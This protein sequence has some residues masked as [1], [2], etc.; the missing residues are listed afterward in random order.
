MFKLA[1]LPAENGDCLWIEYGEPDDPHRILIDTGTKEA[2]GPLRKKILS[3]DTEHR[4]F[5]LMIMSHYDNDHILGA[6]D[7]FQDDELGV[8]FGDI[9][10]NGWAHISTRPKDELGPEE[11]EIFSHFIMKKRLPW[12][13]S[14]SSKA[15]VLKGESPISKTLP[16]GMQITLLSPRSDDLKK[17][18]EDWESRLSDHDL[19]PGFGMEDELPADVLGGDIESPTA[20]DVIEWAEKELKKEPKYTVTSP[21]LCSIAVLA[22]YEGKRCFLAA[23]ASSDILLGS[24]K[25]ICPNSERLHVDLFKLSHHGSRNNLKKGLLDNIDCSKYVISTNGKTHKHPHKE[26]ISKLVLYGKK[27]PSCLYFNYQ[28]KFNEIWNDESFQDEFQYKS[29]Y[30][31]DG[32]LEINI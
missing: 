11:A 1:T 2:Y 26:A 25:S 3:L 13:V 8:K 18:K 17:L 6:L 22:E 14:F 15:V 30:G 24:I 28:T 7:L 27:K 29:I 12:N 23:D 4:S 16:G 10:F 20:D 31:E 32:F 9:W 19:E 21:N 5:E